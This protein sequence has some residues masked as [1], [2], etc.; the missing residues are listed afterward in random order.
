LVSVHKVTPG[1]SDGQNTVITDGLKAGDTVV[2]DGT[3]RL[4][5]GAKIKVAPAQPTTAPQTP[6][7]SAPPPS[8]RKK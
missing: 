2:V 4:S 3:D 8:H 5:D 7:T 1:Q 6:A